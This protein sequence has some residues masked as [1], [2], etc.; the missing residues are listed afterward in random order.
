M[1]IKHNFYPIRGLQFHPEAVL[2]TEGLQLL[3][4]WAFFNKLL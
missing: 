2:T 4:N 3:K 1:A